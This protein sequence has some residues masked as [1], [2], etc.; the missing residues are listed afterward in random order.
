MTALL[1]S[2]DKLFSQFLIHVRKPRSVHVDN[3][4]MKS[5]LYFWHTDNSV[6][7]AFTDIALSR[8]ESYMGV[9]WEE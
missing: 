8:N 5:C 2:I 9:F 6:V 3:I 7:S 1:E 4:K